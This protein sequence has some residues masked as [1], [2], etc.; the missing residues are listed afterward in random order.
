MRRIGVDRMNLTKEDCEQSL[1]HLIKGAYS[2]W[3]MKH[4]ITAKPYYLREK[5]VY[6]GDYRALC[7][8]ERLIDE[9]FE[10][11]RKHNE[12]EEQHMKLLLQWGKSDNPP[13]KFEDMKEGMWVW[14]NKV[15]E[16]FEIFKLNKS[17]SGKTLDVEVQTQDTQF[18]T[19]AF[20]HPSIFKKF[21]ENRFYRYEVISY[22]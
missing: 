14:D 19:F 6:K 7:K 10:L 8:I 3:H 13:L 4:G 17:E 5:P 20:R 16:Y 12:L 18:I 15:K 22:E 11:I 21:E 1:E 2:R 9:Y